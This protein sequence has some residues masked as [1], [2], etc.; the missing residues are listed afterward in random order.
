MREHQHGF[1]RCEQS[2]SHQEG[3]CGAAFRGRGMGRAGRGEGSG[4]GRGRE[5]MFEPGE[6]K[7]L[8]LKL[9]Q[10]NPCHGYEIIKAIEELAGG[11]YSPSP[12]IIYPMLTLLEDTSLARVSK[13]TGGK[14]QY[15]I[16]QE[17]ATLLASQQDALQ[18]IQGR[19]ASSGRLAE[20]RRAPEIQRSV[21][22]FKTALHLR[23]SQGALSS[24]SLRRIADAIDRA[25][26]EI[27][28]AD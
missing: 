10:E 5:R 4:R 2:A 20:A 3:D 15:A 25:A 6:L 16:T 13:D 14:K 21:Q 28:R 11:E 22:N 7:L 26:V 23:L 17:G 24:E 19:L 12:G 27:E 18:R 1:G 8:V 9:L